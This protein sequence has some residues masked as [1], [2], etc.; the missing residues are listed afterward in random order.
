MNDLFLDF[1]FWSTLTF[2]PNFTTL[3]LARLALVGGLLL[4]SDLYLT[5][6]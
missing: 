3:L 4:S 5:L 6:L 2:H 1:Y